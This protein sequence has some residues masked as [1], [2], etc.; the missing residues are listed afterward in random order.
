MRVRAK[1]PEGKGGRVAGWAECRG[2]GGILYNIFQ[3]LIKL[4]L[5]MIT[6]T[7]PFIKTV[8]A[9]EMR[10]KLIQIH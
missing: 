7:P 10:G 4:P 2:G 1:R 5:R 9:P 3:D 6:L 8:I